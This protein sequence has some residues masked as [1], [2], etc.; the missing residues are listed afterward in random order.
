MGYHYRPYRH[1]KDKEYYEQ[2]YTCKFDNSDELDPIP[3]NVQTNTTPPLRNR[4]FK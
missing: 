3:Q 2:F 4:A 1:R